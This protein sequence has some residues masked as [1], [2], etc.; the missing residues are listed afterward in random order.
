MA[1]CPRKEIVLEGEVGVYHCWGGCVRR[2]WLCGLDPLTGRDFG[3]RREWLACRERLL[4]GLFAIE[5]GFH[6]ELANHLHVVLIPDL[7]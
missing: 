5:V 1:A 6:A 7:D 4:A 3:H 2:A